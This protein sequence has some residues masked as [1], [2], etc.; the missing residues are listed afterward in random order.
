[1][2]ICAVNGKAYDIRLRRGYVLITGYNI[3][4]LRFCSIALTRNISYYYLS[5]FWLGLTIL[6]YLGL[7]LL[8]YPAQRQ[9]KWVFLITC[10]VNMIMKYLACLRIV[11]LY[12]TSSSLLVM[13]RYFSTWLCICIEIT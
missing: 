5:S 6:G 13:I 10:L 8:Y 9:F 12:L 3:R 1:M 4:F 11:A 7:A 2:F